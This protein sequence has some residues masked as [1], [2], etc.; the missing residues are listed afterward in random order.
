MSANIERDLKLLKGYA[1][2]S[3]LLIAG[4][5]LSAFSRAPQRAR[6]DEIDV[7][8][9]NVVEKDG[10]LRLVISNRAQSPGPMYRGKPFARP[11]GDRP[12]LIFFNEEGT[13]DGGL[14]WGGRTEN[15][16]YSAGALLAFDQ[17]ETDQVV[18]LQY[19]DNN[20]Q[21]YAGLTF[22]DRAEYPIT[23]WVQE[24]DSVEKLP[25]GPQKEAARK[26]LQ[27]PRNGQPL[28]ASRAYIGRN[29]N[30]EAKVELSDAQ[31]KPRLRLVVDSLGTARLEFLDAEGRVTYSLPEPR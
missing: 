9:I 16:K 6:F 14:T 17:Y 8:R 28:F 15:G 29:H 13:E 19:Q 22:G 21:R 30:K 7:G 1:L 25:E 4:L 26:W 12:G 23:K 2:F 5:M 27:G 3:S 10:T 11:G 31:G 20:G 18:V 24:R